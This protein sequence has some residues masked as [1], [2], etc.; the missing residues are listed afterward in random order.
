MNGEALRIMAGQTMKII[1][2]QIEFTNFDRFIQHT[3][4]KQNSV[5]QPDINPGPLT[6]PKGGK[7]FAFESLDH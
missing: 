3:K 6:R 7:L 4:A 5:V 1:P 2:G